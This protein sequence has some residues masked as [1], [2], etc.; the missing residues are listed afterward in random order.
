MRALCLSPLATPLRGWVLAGLALVAPGMAWAAEGA[1]GIYSCIDAQGRRLTSDRP[2]AECQTREQRVLNR[3]GSV[4]AV[5]PPTLSPEERAQ[6]EAEDR[7][8]AEL[9]SARADAV[10]RDR[11]LMARYPN[12]AAHRKAREAALD[13]VRQA[14]KATEARLAELAR[15]RKPL[16][17]EAEFFKGRT[18][19]AR[20]RQQIDANDAGV[21]AQ[22]SAAA[23]QQTELAR[24]NA[25]YDAELERLRRLWA[26]ALPGSQVP[27]SVP[28][29]EL[30]STPPALRNASQ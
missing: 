29:T 8:L 22:R 24:I 5:V 11:N 27:A 30:T 18:L 23:N 13:T 20:L 4:R 17:D 10:R 16:M 7:R 3:D 15:E 21:E 6:K 26:G 25:L 19:P 9:K 14:T 28:T 12:E 2:I 1:V